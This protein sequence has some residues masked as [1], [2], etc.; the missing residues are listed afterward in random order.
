MIPNIWKKIHIVCGCHKITNEN[1]PIKMMPHEGVNGGDIFYSCPKYYEEN[2]TY[3]EKACGNRIS[4]RDYQKMVEHI[5]DILEDS[6]RNRSIVNLTGM[7]WKN[8]SVEYEIIQHT[9]SQIVI[10]VKNTRT[11]YA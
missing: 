4:I 1:A 2:R 9:G 10:A 8:N 6:Y 11:I 7:K 3:G 5:S